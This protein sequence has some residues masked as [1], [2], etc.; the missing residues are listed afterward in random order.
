VIFLE[1]SGQN[2]NRDGWGFVFFAKPGS[3]IVPNAE[4]LL[5][6]I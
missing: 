1:G 5:C 2:L 3:F 4:V 6:K